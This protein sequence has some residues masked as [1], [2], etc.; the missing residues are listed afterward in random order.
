[1]AKK[2]VL[3][4]IGWEC[5]LEECPPGAFLYN[6]QVCFKSEYRTSN[7]AIEAYN[8]AGEFFC[9]ENKVQPLEYEWEEDAEIYE[10]LSP[11]SFGEHN[12]QYIHHEGVYT[13]PPSKQPAPK[14]PGNQY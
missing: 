6:K 12:N 1:M 11:I 5:S 7:G 13:V 10:N 2:L 8:S 3:N 4:P 14:A 9:G